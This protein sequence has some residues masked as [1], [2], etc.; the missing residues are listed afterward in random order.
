MRQFSL[1]LDDTQRRPTILLNNALTALLDTG[2]YLPI[3]TDD[4]DILVSELGGKLVRTNVPFAGFGGETTGNLYQITLTVG[5]L[6][7]PHLHMI[8]NSELKTSYNMILSATMFDG[9]SYEINTYTHIVSFTAFRD[10]DLVR[11]LVVEDRNGKIYV[12]CSSVG[13]QITPPAPP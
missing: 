7:F 2:A 1:P 13:Y 9:L 5:Q 3:W 11:N 10:E 6:V 4:E 8:A 12:L